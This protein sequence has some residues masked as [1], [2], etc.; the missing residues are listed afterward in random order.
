[1]VMQSSWSLIA[2]PGPSQPQ[3]VSLGARGHESVGC[4]TL[5]LVKQGKR[6]VLLGPVTEGFSVLEEP[7]TLN[8]GVQEN[9]C[10]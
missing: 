2:L 8:L 10:T 1:M 9:R 5:A 4:D 6:G 3:K 7:E